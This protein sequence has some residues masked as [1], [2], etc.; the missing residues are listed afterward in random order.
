VSVVTTSVHNEETD[1]D[2]GGG[3]GDDG[4]GMMGCGTSKTSVRAAGVHI[5]GET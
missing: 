2:D 1:D 5:N 4:A 3:G